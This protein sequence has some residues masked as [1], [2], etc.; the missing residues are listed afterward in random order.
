MTRVNLLEGT[1]EHRV[2]VQKTKVA[3]RRGQQIFMVASAL[4][5]CLIALGVD[6]LWTNNAAAAAKVELDREQKM[7]DALKADTERKTQL[8]N[9]IK[10]IDNRTKVIKDLRASQETPVPILSAINDRMPGAGSDFQIESIKQT[11]GQKENGAS[12]LHL[13]G[14]T[15]DQ[16]VIASFAQRLEKS[17][18]LFTNLSLSTERIKDQAKKTKD[19]EDG[20]DDEDNTRYK[21]TID[22]DYNKPVRSN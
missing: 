19:T 21:F 11:P 20:K 22:C 18:G 13:V 5:L 14:S 8:E 6:H 2:A 1:A 7:A 16:Q 15:I 12:Q 3:A 10:E 9:E 17:D 4:G